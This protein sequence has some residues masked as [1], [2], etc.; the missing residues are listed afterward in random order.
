MSTTRNKGP[1][2][3]SI[4]DQ[5]FIGERCRRC[6]LLL[7]DCAQHGA[8]GCNVLP[9]PFTDAMRSVAASQ[10]NLLVALDDLSVGIRAVW[11]ATPALAR[12]AWEFQ[13]ACWRATRVVD[14]LLKEDKA[15]RK[16]RRQHW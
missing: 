7:A 11:R 2:D 10:A 12:A 3:G 9:D 4:E 6:G 8:G 16:R 13:T 5:V 1:F 14:R 15:A